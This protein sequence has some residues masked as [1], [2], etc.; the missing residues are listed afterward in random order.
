M[1]TGQ[2]DRLGP[3]LTPGRHLLGHAARRPPQLAGI[4]QLPPGPVRVGRSVAAGQH[5]RTLLLGPGVA[6]VLVQLRPDGV[7]QVQQV[8]HVRGGVGDLRVRQGTAPPVREPVALGHGHPQEG[9]AEAGQARRAV[10]GEPG[11]HLGVEQPAGPPPARPLQDL[12][13]LLGG[14]GD[15]QPRTGQDLRAG[16]PCPPPAGR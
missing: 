11:R 2:I 9:L 12:E 15:H 7:G 6:A 13:V 10:A 8:L 1:R 14:V 16:A 5:G 4:A 3:A